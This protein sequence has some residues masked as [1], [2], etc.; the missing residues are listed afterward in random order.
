MLDVMNLQ[1]RWGTELRQ[2][3]R[4]RGRLQLGHSRAGSGGGAGAGEAPLH[5]GVPESEASLTVRS[6]A[7]ASLMRGRGSKQGSRM[8]RAFCSLV[9]VLCQPNIVAAEPQTARTGWAG[10]GA[11]EA[12]GGGGGGGGGGA[13]GVVKAVRLCRG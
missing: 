6:R 3:L 2:G 7:A 8:L 13:G 5:L 1:W 12:E 4:C 9:I 11:G 10:A